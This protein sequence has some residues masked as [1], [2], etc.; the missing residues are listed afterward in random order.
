MTGPLLFLIYINDLA[1]VSSTTL[2]ILF[3]DATNLLLSH[4]NFDSLII[5][6]NSGMAKFSECFQINKC[7]SFQDTRLMSHVTTSHFN[8]NMYFFLSKCV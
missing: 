1:A 4:N 6:A 7:D 3:A 2:P 5:E 8:V